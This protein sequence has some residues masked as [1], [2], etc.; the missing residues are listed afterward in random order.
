MMGDR[1]NEAREK[2]EEL[3]LELLQDSED[4]LWQKSGGENVG[5]LGGVSNQVFGA[6]EIDGEP[7]A[8]IVNIY[9]DPVVDSKVIERVKQSK[10]RNS[11]RKGIK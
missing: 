1:Y 6:V 7:V 3:V 5:P 2:L 9:A 4:T 10:A 11:L 8:F